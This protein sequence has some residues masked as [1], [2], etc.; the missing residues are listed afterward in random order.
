MGMHID[1][2]GIVMT[3]SGQAM[4]QGV[5]PGWKVQHIGHEMYTKKHLEFKKFGAEDYFIC[6]Q[7][8]KLTEAQQQAL[9]QR[10]S[11]HDTLKAK[12]AGKSSL[13]PKQSDDAE[14]D[15]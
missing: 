1:H 13:L 10:V 8:R 14:D 3:V 15:E 9:A 12:A 2:H 5:E 7:I 6:F 4:G 11:E